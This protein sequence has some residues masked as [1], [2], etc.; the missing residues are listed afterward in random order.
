[1][2]TATT[3]IA[4]TATQAVETLEAAVATNLNMKLLQKHPHHLRMFSF[5]EEVYVNILRIIL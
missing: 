4:L 1:M 2:I 3:P 5:K